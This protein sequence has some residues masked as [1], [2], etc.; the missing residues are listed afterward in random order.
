MPHRLELRRY[1]GFTLID[2]AYNSNPDGAKVALETLSMFAGV[3]IV[4]TPGLVELGSEETAR[5]QELGEYAAGRCDYALIVGRR[6]AMPIRRGLLAGQM[7][8]ERIYI[9]DT[10]EQAL[11]FVPSLEGEQKTVLLL[12][13]LPDNY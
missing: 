10:I 8:E 7:A 6:R 11:A 2:D 12:N 13:D 3:R 1:D 9:F 4:I 5:N